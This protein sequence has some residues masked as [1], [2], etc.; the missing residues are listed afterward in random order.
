VSVEVN[1]AD[2]MDRLAIRELVENWF[3]HRDNRDWE[4]FLTVWHADGVM[5]TTWGG[6]T[7]PRGFTEAAQRGYDRGERML[8]SCGPTNVQLGG[9]RAVAQSKLRIMQRGEV[10]GVLCDVTCIGRVYDFYEKREGR[11]GLV[12]RQ[13]IYERDFI[14]PVD[15]A[16]TVTLDPDKLAALPDG[17]ARLGYLQSGLGY[18]IKPDMPTES[19]PELEALLAQGES[20]LGGG[21]LTWE[22]ATAGA[23]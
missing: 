22:H 17:Y 9:D 10:E 20:W 14:T 16:Q 7:S 1:P 15:P 5:M 13:P 4:K 8:H 19:G 21:E 18:Q 11:W 23:S 2:L 12:L 6:R 3:V